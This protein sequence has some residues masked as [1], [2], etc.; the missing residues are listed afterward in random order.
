MARREY[1][2]VTGKL[3]GYSQNTSDRLIPIGRT[4]AIIILAV[5]FAWPLLKNYMGW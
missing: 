1:R 3:K 2:D 4:A 5:F